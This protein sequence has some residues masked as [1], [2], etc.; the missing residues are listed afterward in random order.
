MSSK[1]Y[2]L[3]DTLLAD[4]YEILRG[5]GAGGHGAVYLAKDLQRAGQP[6]VAIKTLRSELLQDPTSLKRFLREGEVLQSLDHRNVIK[7]Y[8]FGESPVPWLALEYV[9]GPILSELLKAEQRFAPERAAK[10]VAQLLAGLAVA[11]D[12]KISHRDLKPSNIA[13]TSDPV[14][15]LLKL[16]DFGVAL[17]P[18]RSVASTR[19]TAT[20]EVVGTPMYLAPER[21]T[22]EDGGDARSDV[23]SVGII[24]FELVT[25]RPPFV[26]DTLWAQLGKMLTEPAPPVASLG[27]TVDPAFQA[28]LTTALQ[29]EPPNRYQ[30]AGAMLTAVQQW[31]DGRL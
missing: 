26:A 20:G 2:P 11:H 7:C 30:D 9:D 13:F 3:V 28:L 1:L 14:N 21:I 5:L 18:P 16:L 19:L 29:A 22:R 31:L 12:K 27:V 8:G 10:I 6:L 4:R 24:L 25:G 23:W 17:R 15:P